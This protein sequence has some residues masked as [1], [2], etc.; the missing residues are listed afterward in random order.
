MNTFAD[1]LNAELATDYHRFVIELA[2]VAAVAYGLGRTRAGLV[3]RGDPGRC[4]R[5]GGSPCAPF[6]PL[7]AAASGFRVPG[8]TRD[9]L[10]VRTRGGAL[11]VVARNNS[12]PLLFRPHPRRPAFAATLAAAGR[13]AVGR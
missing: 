3:L 1:G 12:R 11:L 5:T 8:Q 6:T 9:V 4:A 2:L 7:S 10:R 13:S